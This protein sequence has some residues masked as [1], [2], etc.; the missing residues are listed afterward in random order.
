MKLNLPR[1][2]FTVLALVLINSVTK[3]QIITT[4]AGMGTNGFSGDG[5]LATS[6]Q[7]HSPYGMCFDPAG[8]LYIADAL[9]HRIRMINTAGIITTVAGTGTAGY[10]GDGNLA[11]S[12]K[13]NRPTD[14]ATDA[15][16][17]LYIA[18][19]FNNC[20]RKVN[21]SGIIS[22]YAGTTVSG[23]TGDGGLAISATMT[24]PNRMSID[25]SGNIYISLYQSSV[26]RMV[27]TS[28]IISTFAGTGTSGFSG[29]G[30]LATAAQ[31]D[32]PCKIVADNN[33]NFFLA[34]E[35]NQRI[36]K[37]NSSGIITT[38]AGNG[39]AAFSGDGSLATSASINFIEGI[40]VDISGN[41]YIPDKS[42]NRIRKVNTSGII[43]TIAGTGSA[44]YTGDGGNAISATINTPE[45][46]IFDSYGNLYFSDYGNNAIRKISNVAIGI[47]KTEDNNTEV[48]VFPNPA[49]GSALIEIVG[50]N[51][52]GAYKIFNAM[53][54]EVETGVLSLTATQLNLQ[55][56]SAGIYT[57]VITQK[58]KLTTTKLLVEK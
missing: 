31:F 48:K 6:A 1:L 26:Y 14:V 39:S 35:Y 40:S 52:P 12:A 19:E 41:L 58:S 50:Q 9:N 42:N 24:Q 22:T 15:A 18:D 5:G 17:N 51:E 53:G 56:L 45:E 25:V 7:L 23:Y 36:R 46:I 16:G 10:S 38:V 20:I 27:N 55:K 2:S 3:A 37:I 47:K 57:I 32:N 34:D 30:G 49:S 54:Q 11:T 13:L 8:N 33:G 29:D 4:V 28:G 43:S 21:T 44:G